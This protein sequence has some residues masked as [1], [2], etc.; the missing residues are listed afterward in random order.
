[1]GL[2]PLVTEDIQRVVQSPSPLLHLYIPYS[3][4]SLSSHTDDVVLG[5]A[6]RDGSG[7][8]IEAE[9]DGTGGGARDGRSTG[10]GNRTRGNSASSMFCLIIGASDSRLRFT[11]L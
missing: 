3:P 7:G 8:R 5:P 9:V 1:M 10:S 4:N 2:L 6:D 11:T